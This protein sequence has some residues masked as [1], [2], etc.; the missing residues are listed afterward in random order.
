MFRRKS[1]IAQLCFLPTVTNLLSRLKGKI[2]GQ[3]VWG[4]TC[5]QNQR[6]SK[7][8]RKLQCLDHLRFM[9][10]FQISP[11]TDLIFAGFL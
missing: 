11:F 3:E 2:L 5:K 7:A 8:G 4:K 10:D 9:V 1:I 6:E